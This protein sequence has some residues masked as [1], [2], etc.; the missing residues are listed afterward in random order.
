MSD[1]DRELRV[2]RALALAEIAVRELALWYAMYLNGA[3]PDPVSGARD[4]LSGAAGL[5]EGA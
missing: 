3:V 4:A 1:L 2:L 5:L